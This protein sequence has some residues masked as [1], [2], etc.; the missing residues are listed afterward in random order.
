VTTTDER[1]WKVGEL[2]RATGLTVRAL[3]HFDEIGLLRPAERSPA[4]HRW[5]TGEDVRRLYRIVA[6]RHLG[7]PLAGI[8]ASLDGDAGELAEAVRRQLDQVARQVELQHRLRRRLEA[9]VRAIERAGEPSIDEL[10]EAME[11]IMETRTFTDEQLAILQ[12]RHRE[13]GDEGFQRWMG[14]LAELAAEFEGHIRRGTDPVDPAAQAT[15]RG[16]DELMTHMTGGDRAILSVMYSV[17]DDKGAEAASRGVV[18][19]EVWDYAKRTFAV[20]FGRS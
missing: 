9:I 13:A 10:I 5:Y 18:S 19:A 20:G 1:R 14:R 2:A 6:L 3:H 17:M 7:L 12:R 11:A 15:A 16:W 4:G 8:A